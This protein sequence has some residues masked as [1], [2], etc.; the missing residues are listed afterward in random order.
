[1]KV[2]KRKMW[3]GIAATVVLLVLIAAA[4]LRPAEAQSLAQNMGQMSE[5]VILLFL[6]IEMLFVL[7]VSVALG[8]LGRFLYSLAVYPHEKN[9]VQ[10][11]MLPGEDEGRLVEDALRKEL[12]L[13]E[14]R[15]EKG[16]EVSQEQSYLISHL[17]D[18]SARRGHAR[19]IG[20][21]V[22][23]SAVILATIIAFAPMAKGLLRSF[24]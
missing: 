15:R 11:I 18:A 22:F 21:A 23:S 7:L 10:Q 3:I 14:Q 12:A 8:L 17:A 5:G 4:V 19:L 1:M 13:R 20:D 24:F 6:T 2:S 9:R 16:E